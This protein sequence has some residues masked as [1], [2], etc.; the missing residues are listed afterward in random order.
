MDGRTVK[1]KRGDR[2]DFPYKPVRVPATTK[3]SAGYYLKPELDWVD[4]L[5]GSEG[6][7]GIVTEA[8]LQLLPEPAAILSGVVF[9]PSDVLALDAVDAWRSTPELRLL[10]FIDEHALALLRPHYPEIPMKAVAALLVEQ[11]L[12]SEE[13]VEVDL[14]TRRLQDQQA[15][16]EDSWFGF[17]ASERERFRR[18]RHTLPVT[19]LETV[20][21]NGFPKSGTDF[22]VPIERHR[23]LYSYYKE[24]CET[25]FPGQYT[26]YGHVGDANNHVNLFP[27]TPEQAHQAEELIHEFAQYVVFLGGT[28]AAEHGVG[29][30]KVDLLRMMYSDDEIQ[31]MRDVK[32]HL[33]PDWLLGRG[34]IFQM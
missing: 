7:L 20:R 18:F 34:T 13:D 25:L 15:F 9:F 3:N 31:A 19:V 30:S 16:E 5:S 11:N 14:W 17:A 4:L 8:E 21:R 23:E 26:I 2:V 6:T 1:V 22:A 33:D 27:A 12:Q 28:I 29:K 10:E 24:R 32:R